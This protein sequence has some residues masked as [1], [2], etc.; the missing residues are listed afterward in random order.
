MST[1]YFPDKRSVKVVYFC[2]HTLRESFD[3]AHFDKEHYFF[4]YDFATRFVSDK[5]ELLAF[6]MHCIDKL[7]DVFR[8]SYVQSRFKK[9][10]INFFNRRR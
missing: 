3:F 2:S 9:C 7:L 5:K 6:C 1:D 10:F 4:Q 8:I